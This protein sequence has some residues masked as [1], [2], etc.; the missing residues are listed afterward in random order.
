MRAYAFEKARV[1][2]PLPVGKSSHGARDWF[3]IDERQLQ[4]MRCGADHNDGCEAEDGER[5]AKSHGKGLYV[6]RNVMGSLVCLLRVETAK[7]TG[8]GRGAS[9]LVHTGG[10][11]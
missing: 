11:P 5:A 8:A 4:Q 7:Q 3:P 9:L 1:L 2:R 6:G 10:N